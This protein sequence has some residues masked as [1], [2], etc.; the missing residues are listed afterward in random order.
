[1]RSENELI[2]PIPIAI[3]AD[4]INQRAN[5]MYKGT[6]SSVHSNNMGILFKFQE[7]L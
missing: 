1:L 3:P 6:F 2:V 4:I 7:K 5:K